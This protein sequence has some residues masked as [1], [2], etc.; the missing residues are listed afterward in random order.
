MKNKNGAGKYQEQIVK[1]FYKAISEKRFIEFYYIDKYKKKEGTR[2]GEA[3]LIGI[4]EK[5][6]LFISGVFT[7]IEKNNQE[8][9]GHKNFLIDQIKE[10]SLKILPEKFN[11]LKI[12]AEKVYRLKESNVLCAVYFPEAIAKA[13]KK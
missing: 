13:Y 11:H 2:K 8:N 1:Q 3:Y 5:G 10:G 9:S 12:D 7:A 4:N 6:N